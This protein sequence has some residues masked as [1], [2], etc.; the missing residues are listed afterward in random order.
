MTKEPFGKLPKT[1]QMTILPFMITQNGYTP[2][3]KSTKI[4]DVVLKKTFSRHMQCCSEGIITK[5]SSPTFFD[6][7]STSWFPQ[8]CRKT[9][10]PKPLTGKRPVYKQKEKG[11]YNQKLFA[12]KIIATLQTVP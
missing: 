12:L 2:I 3:V 11:L 5:I 1:P 4:F 10:A 7:D 8:A 6:G 9:L